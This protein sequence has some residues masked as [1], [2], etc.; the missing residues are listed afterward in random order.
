[1]ITLNQAVQ[2]FLQYLDYERSLSQATLTAYRADLRNLAQF[3]KDQSIPAT[4]ENLTTE[5]IRSY[6]AHLSKQ[7]Y[8]ASTV[9]RRIATFSSMF[10]YL[11]MTRQVQHN[12]M[13]AIRRPKERKKLPT[14]LNKAECRKLMEAAVVTPHV[15]L[16]FRNRA[17]MGVLIYAGL[18]K[19][20][21]V[22]LALEDVDLERRALKVVDGKGG[23]DRVIPICDELHDI[24]KDWIEMRPEVDHNALFTGLSGERLKGGGLHVMFAGAVKRAGLASKN[25]TVH[26]LR[27]TFATLMLGRGVDLV[28][29]Q[30]LLGHASLDTTSIYLHVGADD[31]RNAVEGMG[32]LI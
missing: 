12:P 10:S 19:S 20:E 29:I 30:R 8:S 3:L 1:V 9:G 21:V 28:S 18:R 15:P 25:V 14:T 23:Q 24:L 6:I 22:G 13:L 5:V 11:L 7:G 4:L 32:A 27:H 26:T 2:E 31:L 17:L 16:A